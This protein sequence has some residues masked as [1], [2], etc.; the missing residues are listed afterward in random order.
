MIDS[1]DRRVGEGE[2][3]IRL[4]VT[5]EGTGVLTLCWPAK[6]NGRAWAPG[7]GELFPHGQATA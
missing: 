1:L 2:E 7:V 5:A 6:L 4:D 3:R